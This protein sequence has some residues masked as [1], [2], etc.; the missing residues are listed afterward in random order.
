MVTSPASRSFV[1]VVLCSLLAL[2]PTPSP[3]T[4][5][6]LIAT[7]DAAWSRRSTG[8]QGSRAAAEPIQEAIEAYRQALEQDPQDLE[9]RWKFLRALYFKGEFVLTDKDARLSLFETGREI[10]DIGRRQVEAEFD[11]PKDS[12]KMDPEEVAEAIGKNN[13]VAEIYFWSS[14]HWG[15]WG[16]Y[17]GKIAAARQ[18]VAGKIRDLA[19]IV[20]LLDDQI[21]NGGGH[22]VLGRLHSEAPKIP[23]ITGWID[24]DLSIRELRRA[25][26]IAPHDKLTL[27]FLAD[28]LA[29][30]Q[31]GGEP[32]ALEILRDLVASEPD[33]VW[34]VEDHKTLDDAR[35]LLAELEE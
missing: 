35:A 21:E 16:R 34:L 15:L 10:A 30:Y 29:K 1:P 6:E 26:E 9:A 28:A 7:G 27:Y 31:K 18:G 17:R 20:I 2:A 3:A 22:R 24:H 23:F 25:H 11:L 33:P 4:T 5:A 13:L 14:T 8:H 32:E 19:Q 12:L